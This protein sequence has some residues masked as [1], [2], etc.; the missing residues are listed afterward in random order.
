MRTSLSRWL[1]PLFLA[2]PFLA[3]AADYWPLQPGTEFRF[4][5]GGAWQE[6]RYGESWSGDGIVRGGQEGPYD[7]NFYHEFYHDVQADDV[8][9]LTHGSMCIDYIDP[10]WY[11]IEPPALFLDLPLSAG[12][13]WSCTSQLLFWG[14]LPAGELTL[15]FLVAGEE[16]VTV[17]AGTF[18]VMVVQVQMIPRGALA[19][20]AAI[21]FLGLP[22]TLYLQRQL[23]PV[24]W[25]EYELVSW[26][27]IVDATHS[28][29]G[30]VKALY[31]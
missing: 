2:V 29:W 15:E 10:D 12:K 6:V 1:L 8:Y 28:T 27:G 4:E 23:G 19:T 14:S 22:D 9:L 3:A 26:E 31:R 7:C 24:R 20:P 17:P 25:D 18:T 11:A 30:E 13:S 21:Y 5:A 16:Q